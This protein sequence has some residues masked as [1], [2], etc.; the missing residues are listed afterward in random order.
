[1]G[2]PAGLMCPRFGTA[3]V[4]MASWGGSAQ[5]QPYSTFGIN[6][7]ETIKSCEQL[8]SSMRMQRRLSADVLF[9][10][11]SEVGKR[12]SVGSFARPQFDDF[13]VLALKRMLFVV[14]LLRPFPVMVLWWGAIL[15]FLF[16]YPKGGLRF[17]F[18]FSMSVHRDS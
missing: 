12:S 8:I 3:I 13:D 17:R 6:K 5:T 18:I 14:F 15:G 16:I 9:K 10:V 1:M 11:N 4:F 7:Q 2:S